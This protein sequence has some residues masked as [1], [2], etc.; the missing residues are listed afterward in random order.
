MITQARELQKKP[1]VVV[2]T[3]GRLA[4]HIESCDTF[5]LKNLRFLVLDEAD[6]LFN[7]RFNAQMKT[8]LDALPKQKQTLLF[9]ATMTQTLEQVKH[10]THNKV[11]VWKCSEE[12]TTVEKLEQ[13]YVLCPSHARNGYLVETIRSFLAE[14]PDSSV[15]VFTD[16]C[17]NCQVISMALNEI[18]MENAP[19]HSMISQKERLLSL[20]RFKSESARIL[21]ATDVASRGLDIPMVDLVV[22]HIMPNNPTDYI[23]RVGRTARAGRIGSAISLITQYEISLLRS[24]EERINQKFKEYDVSGKEVA[25]VLTQV[26][27][28]VREMQVKLEETDFEE[29]RL[30]NKRKN[31]IRMGYDPDELEELLKKKKKRRRKGKKDL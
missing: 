17:K 6:R 13:Y 31:L 21:I 12:V 30:I 1:H 23:H 26:N 20:Q 25:K 11:F 4:D 8:I 14:N 5:S 27:V 10:V 29:K 28:T 16:T 24:V 3:P 2:A 7:G 18:G 15:M 19:L 9:S 22:N